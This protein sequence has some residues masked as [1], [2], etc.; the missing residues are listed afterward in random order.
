MGQLQQRVQALPPARTPQE[1][2]Q[3]A[4]A[5]QQAQQQIQ[6]QVKEM[7]ARATAQLAQRKQDETEKWHE[8]TE[9][10][11]GQTLEGQDTRS[12]L[13]SQTSQRD[14][15]RHGL[16]QALSSGMI[17]QDVY[18]AGIAAINKK[19]GSIAPGASKGAMSPAIPDA[20]YSKL[21]SAVQTKFGEDADSSKVLGQTVVVDGKSYKVVEHD[22]KL[23]FDP[24]K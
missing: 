23:D 8:K 12:R 9:Q 11:W 5:I 1:Q 19:Y 18:D 3:R 4:L 21:V 15:D 16:D 24:V 2:Y 7:S 17:S 22:G 13:T 14:T 20:T 6:A 10:H